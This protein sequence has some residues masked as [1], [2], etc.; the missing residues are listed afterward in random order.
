MPTLKRRLSAHDSPDAHR[1]PDHR[2][3]AVVLRGAS[4]SS[5]KR[6]RR[7]DIE[8]D[9]SPATWVAPWGAFFTQGVDLI[10]VAAKSAFNLATTSTSLPHPDPR[11]PRRL[12][13][14]TTNGISPLSRRELKQLRQEHKQIKEELVWY[15]MEARAQGGEVSKDSPQVFDLEQRLKAL[16]L[17]IEGAQRAKH[18]QLAANGGFFGTDASPARMAGG[19]N[20]LLNGAPGTSGLLGGYQRKKPMGSDKHKADLANRDRATVEELRRDA[21]LRKAAST[22]DVRTRYR[23]LDFDVDDEE[24][25][26]EAEDALEERVYRQKNEQMLKQEDAKLGSKHI[27]LHRARAGETAMQHRIPLTTSSLVRPSALDRSL[28]FPGPSAYPTKNGVVPSTQLGR[29]ASSF[30]LEHTLRQAKKTMAEPTREALEKYEQMQKELKELDEKAE[31][32][33]EVVKLQKRQF[34]KALS[35]EHQARAKAIFAN[36]AYDVS[37]KGGSAAHRDIIRLKDRTWLNDEIVNFYGAMINA[38][39]DEA[40]KREAKEGPKA[41]GEG[42][43]RLRK[44]FCFNTHFWNMFGD[45]GFSRVK[46][47][48][49]RF[50]TFE[51]DIIIVPI[52]HNNSH[53]VCAAVNIALKR[54]EYYDSL[55]NPSAFVYDR[56]RRWLAEE[57]KSKKGGKEIDLSEWENF[58][59]TDVPLQANADDCGV[60]TCMF[61][62]SLSR[63]VDGFDFEQKNMPYLRHRIAIEIDQ[64]KL[65]D[66][67]P[68]A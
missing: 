3:D 20:G 46:R 15:R 41:R 30:R 42:V 35:A 36:R 26:P 58:W 19:S 63:D 53:W 45:H 27:K 51:K 16:K 24:E 18:S 44:A 49:K 31:L 67:E 11:A 10:K 57:H 14:P 1:S 50:D 59:M 60:F 68:W 21:Q 43:K 12:S 64:Q 23:G 37:M 6:V 28:F 56:L 48:T 25:A 65:L 29:S 2:A 9:S 33:L 66:L 7:D 4:P 55:G 34:P 17:K 62:E 8:Q 22:N 39:S 47:W 54:F 38:R 5:N 61:M 40:D 32:E 13:A 52:N